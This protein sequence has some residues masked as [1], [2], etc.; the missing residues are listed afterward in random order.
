MPRAGGAEQMRMRHI[1]SAVVLAVIFV[2]VDNLIPRLDW[3]Y[4][5]R[6]GWLMYCFLL[7]PWTALLLAPALLLGKVSRFLY[8]PA[9]LVLV[10]VET[11]TMFIR[12][13]FKVQMDGSWVAIVAGSS[14]REMGEFVGRYFGATFVLLS[15]FVVAFAVFA[16][17]TV[18]HLRDLRHSWRHVLA[19]LACLGLFFLMTPF[20][21]APMET[22]ESRS[23]VFFLT[24]AV[25]KWESY[26]LLFRMNGAPQLPANLRRGRG[27]DASVTGV[28]VIGE[29][30]SRS[31]WHLYGYGRPTTPCV[32]ALGSSV[33][34]FSN[35]TA[36]TAY[37]GQAIPLMMTSATLEAPNDFRYSFS[38][39][40]SALGYRTVLFANQERMGKFGAPETYVFDGCE[41]VVFLAETGKS[42][43]WY[44]DALLPYLRGE[45]DNG[46]PGRPK[47][48]FLHLMGSHIN[49]SERYPPSFAPFAARPMR[50]SCEGEDTKMMSD[51]Y[52]NSIAFT[53]K[54]LGEVV[55]MLQK[56][57]GPSWMIYL[58]DHGETPDEKGWR[59]A[60]S[61]QL[62]EVPMVV[63]LSPEYRSRFPEIVTMLKMRAAEPQRSDRLLDLFLAV[64]GVEAK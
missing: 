51:H 40:L 7:I 16:C 59:T 15:V 53:D 26:R 49:V 62:W 18:S 12:W 27:V 45:L 54:L 2:G 25:N 43:V 33:V 64:A 31:R 4:M 38:Q 34:V 55:A 47:V 32:E 30:A 3:S 46:D 35:V 9:V 63:W 57:G 28:F 6:N 22:L 21:E 17:R 11:V 56:K 20:P 1:V 50:H 37:T 24:D 8:Y 19:G 29:S 13:Q 60:T 52:D 42:G 44:D 36:A 48:S 5:N 41:D 14:L 39:A 10:F 61:R 58:S 23:S